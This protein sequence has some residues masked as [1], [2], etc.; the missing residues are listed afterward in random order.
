MEEWPEGP[1][2]C[3]SDLRDSPP[4]VQP[5]SPLDGP[6]RGLRGYRRAGTTVLKTESGARTTLTRHCRLPKRA[7]TIGRPQDG[8]R[9]RP[10]S[11]LERRWTRGQAIEK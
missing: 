1:P 2:L 8:L 10:E 3:R 4:S 5:D 9:A 11:G 6:G 7:P